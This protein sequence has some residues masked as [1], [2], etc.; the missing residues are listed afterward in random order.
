M[1]R[2]TVNAVISQYRKKSMY[3]GELKVITY[4]YVQA[5]DN[6]L[7]WLQI[8]TWKN[9]ENNVAECWSYSIYKCPKMLPRPW[10]TICSVKPST[11]F[12]QVIIETKLE[13]TPLRYHWRVLNNPSWSCFL[14]KEVKNKFKQLQIKYKKSDMAFNKNHTHQP[15]LNLYI[16]KKSMQSGLHQ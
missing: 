11:D 13:Y 3:R 1:E 9:T 14:S 6:H 5:H 4:T 16:L 8:T 2:R 10:E 15:E 7:Q 12:V